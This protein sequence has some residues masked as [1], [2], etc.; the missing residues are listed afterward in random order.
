MNLDRRSTALLRRVWAAWQV[1]ARDALSPE[2]DTK[3][4]GQR[5][6]ASRNRAVGTGS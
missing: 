4:L 6:P 1:V 3:V 2:F 5:L